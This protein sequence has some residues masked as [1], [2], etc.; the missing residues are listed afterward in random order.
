VR[1]WAIVFLGACG[2]A[3][4]PLVASSPAV[5]P[6]ELAPPANQ[7]LSLVLEG[8]G[9]QH[10]ECTGT[11]VFA[12]TLVAPK[13]ELFDGKRKVGTHTFGPSWHHADGSSVVGRKVAAATVDPKAIPWFLLDVASHG[14]EPGVLA[15]VTA[16]Q[17][18]D[19]TGGLPPTIACDGAHVGAKSD[20]P[21][22]ARYFFYRT[23]ERPNGR[24][25]H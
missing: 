5:V 14:P 10:Y 9:V 20:A 19:T 16:I 3:H 1:I 18:L 25:G 24:C 21:Y 23:S 4:L 6:A 12:W 17:R 7:E 2:G 22:T 15:D 11:P 13:A 8:R